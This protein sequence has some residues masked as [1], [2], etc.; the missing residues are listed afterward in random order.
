MKTTES[1]V[2]ELQRQRELPEQSTKPFRMY[3][4]YASPYSAKMRSYLRYKEIPFRRMRINL[5]IYLTHDIPRLVGMPI[6]PVVLT[7]DNRVMWDST[8][9]IE[10]FEQRY[11]EP[12]VLPADP[13]LRL[14]STLVEDF[15]DEYLLRLT[16]HC[17]WSPSKPLNRKVLSLRLARSMVYGCPEL[18]R[19]AIA[20]ML[21]ERQTAFLPGLGVTE[22]TAEELDQQL[23]ELIRLLDAH[24]SELTYL[25]GGRPTNADFALYGH[26]HAAY[27]SDPESAGVLEEHGPQVCHWIERMT[28][29]G[30]RRGELAPTDFGPLL[31]LDRDRPLPEGLQ[32]L[33]RFA[34]RTWLPM[35]A[36]C[37]KASV[38]RQKRYV[39]PLSGRD[40]EFTTHHYRAWSFE[41]VQLAW[42]A[43]DDEQRARL[44]PH[45]TRAELLPGLD[46]DIEHNGLFDGLPHPFVQDGM[47]DNRI[48]HRREKAAKT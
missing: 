37:A 14:L 3:E 16:V 46:T 43:L 22:S 15:C 10:W 23:V 12:R 9:M 47:A 21:L 26:F 8:P 33:L 45:L 5:G 20:S 1:Q 7:P 30:D 29:F 38:Q 31:V 35:S 24:F 32:R 13:A 18:D 19:H 39:A 40:V 42:T 17:R 44:T 6:L 2:A 41:Q 34:A 11:P 36:A 25:F 48:R 4:D 27:Q 28:D